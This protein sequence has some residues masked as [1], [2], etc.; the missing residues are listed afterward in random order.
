MT[1][2]IRLCSQEN[3]IQDESERLETEIQ[4][5][6]SEILMRLFTQKVTV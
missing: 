6:E 1:L 5:T 3:L 2:I 4:E